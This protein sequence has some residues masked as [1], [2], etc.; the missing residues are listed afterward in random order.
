MRAVCPGIQAVL[1]LD[2]DNRDRREEAAGEGIQV[3]RWERYEA[4]SYLLH[5]DSL[6]RFF[7]SQKVPLFGSRAMQEFRDQ[8]PPVFL[9]NPLEAIAFLRSEPASKTLLP[10]LLEVAGVDLPKRE[11]APLA[12][13]ML[14]AE[15]PWEVVE[16]LDAIHEVVG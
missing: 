9:K 11:Y 10:R 8:M 4:E 7:E 2:G 5:P 3:L 12:R 6:S 13:Q 14:P 1:P 16:K 15:I